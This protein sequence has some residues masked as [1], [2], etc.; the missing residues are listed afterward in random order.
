MSTDITVDQLLGKTDSHITWLS[1]SIGVHHQMLEKFQLMQAAAQQ[2][3]IDITIAS[4]FRSFERQLAIWNRKVSG[5]LPV[6]N[7]NNQPVNLSALAPFEQL[8]AILLYSAL[9]G[10]SRH[11]W[12]CDIDVY[13]ADAL[14]NS[15]Q[16]KLELWEY[17]QAGPFYPLTCWLDK[18]AS[19]FGF[20]RPYQRYQGGVAAE[21]WHLSY[22]PLSQL[23]LGAFNKVGITELAKLLTNSD[24]QLQTTI[25]EQLNF[26]TE[27][28]INNISEFSH[29]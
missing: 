9:P 1:K 14:L 17:Q 16:L 4:G 25:V 24:I 6:N 26:I 12:G 18:N 20:Y 29:G 5:E 13:S 22:A 27:Q 28:Y 11:H 21:P 23:F 8:K 10:T 3:G 7:L 15:Q 2:D 19:D